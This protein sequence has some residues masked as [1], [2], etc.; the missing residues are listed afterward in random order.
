MK[1][2]PETHSQAMACLACGLAGL[3]PPDHFPQESGPW[4][5]PCPECGSLAVWVS[6]P[7][8]MEE[9]V[10]HSE[11]YT[12]SEA[13]AAGKCPMCLGSGEVDRVVPE[14]GLYECSLCG[15]SGEWPP[16]D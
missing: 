13:V 3:T 15:G 12:P 6:E 7:I 9:R 16:P 4:D 2:T 11:P 10:T 5:Q 1:V 14:P 8:P